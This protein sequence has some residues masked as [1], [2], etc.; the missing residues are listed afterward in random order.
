MILKTSPTYLGVG[1]DVCFAEVQFPHAALC[2]R[3]D[4]Q[5][6]EQHRQRSQSRARDFPARSENGIGTNTAVDTIE[7]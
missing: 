7:L 1:S 6:A 2:E 5:G 4:E 3:E